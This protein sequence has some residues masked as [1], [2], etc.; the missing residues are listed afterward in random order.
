MTLNYQRIL[1]GIDGSEI[2]QRALMAAVSVAK[3]NQATLLVASVVPENEY[4]S[5]AVG[6]SI[7]M[8]EYEEHEATK[9][10]NHAVKYAEE[11]GV[12][13]TIPLVRVANPRRELALKLPADYK[14]D[15]IIL[16]LTGK[17]TIGRLFMGSVAQYVSI[18][19]LCNVLLVK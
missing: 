18:H 3:R 19:A 2:S 9:L 14:I 5:V 16:G 10:V 12:S 13:Q 1:V 15:L 7:Q 8:V 4:A 17:G 11:Q 6:A